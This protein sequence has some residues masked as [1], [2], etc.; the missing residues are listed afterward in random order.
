MLAKIYSCAVTDLNGTIIEVEVDASYQSM[1]YTVIVG[2]P[3]IAVQESKER[4]RSAIR[5]SDLEYPRKKITINLA[6]AEL[7][8]E[9]P[10]FDLPIAVGILLASGVIPSDS[11]EDSLIIGELSLDGSVRHVRGVLPITACAKESGFKRVFVPAVDAKE[12]ALI[13]DIDVYPVSTLLSLYQH[14]S[15]FSQIVLQESMKITQTIPEVLTD[16]SEIKGQEH[17]KRGLELAAAGSHNVLM[18]G[19]PGTGKTLMARALPSILPALSIDE[20]LD[21]TRIYSIADQL[22]SDMPLIQSRPFRSPHHTISNVGLVGG[23]NHPHPGEI[24]MAHRGVLF[25]DEFPE[26]GQRV[27]EVLRQ[28]LEDKV[29][30]ISRASGSVCFPANFMLVAAM[31][32]CPC[33]NYGDSGR[34]CTCSERM[35]TQYQKRISGP[36][37]DRIDIHLEVPRVDFQKLSSVQIGESSATIRARVEIAREIQRQ[38][39]MDNAAVTCNS[40]MRPAEIRKFCKLDADGDRFMRAAM[41]RFQFSARVYHRLLKLSRTIADLNHDSEIRSECVAEALQYR[42]KRTD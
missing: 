23:G 42:P 33:G 37:M 14:L 21:V 39:F 7:R 6:P 26:F 10:S 25:L 35:I 40:E 11:L 34:A 30:T 13:P 17:V 28:P 36:L 16:F 29:V 8:K 5:N 22:P 20:A 12:A 3:D 9:G 32:P 31:N 4:V 27:L 18:I 38:R 19:P 15:G 41:D 1:P 2:L 24:S